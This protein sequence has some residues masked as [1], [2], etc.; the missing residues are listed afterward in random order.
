MSVLLVD[1]LDCIEIDNSLAKAIF[2]NFN[3][4]YHPF[5]LR[6]A[7]VDF[8]QARPDKRNEYRRAIVNDAELGIPKH[9]SVLGTE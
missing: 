5:D 1:L 9:L 3:P 8:F 4:D 6:T 2:W 7:L